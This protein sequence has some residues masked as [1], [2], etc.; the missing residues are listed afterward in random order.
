MTEPRYRRADFKLE[1]CH[2]RRIAKPA[3]N[4]EIATDGELDYMAD[5]A[6]LWSQ[7]GYGGIFAMGEALFTLIDAERARREWEWNSDQAMFDAICA[8]NQPESKWEDVDPATLPKWSEVS[9]PPEYPEIPS[10]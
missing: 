3:F 10:P 1:Q 9:G 2:N 5:I 8:E 6:Q 7:S 4:V